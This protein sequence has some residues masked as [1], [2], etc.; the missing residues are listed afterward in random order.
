MPDIDFTAGI[1]LQDDRV[2]A[3]DVEAIDAAGIHVKAGTARGVT[4]L[5]DV[6]PWA[7]VKA[8]MLAS[9]DHM[10][11]SAGY[12][13]SMA[14][15][16]EQQERAQPDQPAEMRQR[17]LGLLAEAAPRICPLGAGCPLATGG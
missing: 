9:T 12:L 6:V 16:V 17:A 13:F 2:M 11:E 5:P 10:L 1:T 7:D 3:A 4:D 15:L 14:E 8:V